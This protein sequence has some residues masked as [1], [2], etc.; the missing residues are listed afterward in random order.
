M[1]R[2]ALTSVVLSVMLTPACMVSEVNV[3]P[4]RAWTALSGSVAATDLD[5]DGSLRG[6]T[7]D[8]LGLGGR[9]SN[10]RLSLRWAQG[11]DRWELFGHST[12]S[13]GSGELA[14]DL[15]L[16][17]VTLVY[18][19]GVVDTDLRIGIYG[20]RWVR[21]VVERG[22]LEIGLG[23]SLVVAE[24]DLDL[25]QDVLDSDTGVPTGEHKS[26]GEYA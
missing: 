1:N 15:H 18:D 24:F 12:D 20:L 23:A 8:E 4:A 25:D 14:D 13:K 22:P 17:G 2:L 21:S 9:K 16:G 7:L 10:E 26:T 3:E 5:D 6:S 11:Q 19:Q